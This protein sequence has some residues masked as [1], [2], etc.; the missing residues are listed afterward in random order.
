MKHKDS[1]SNRVTGGLHTSG[2]TCLY[3]THTQRHTT[4]WRSSALS[5]WRQFS[6]NNRVKAIKHYCLSIRSPRESNIKSCTINKSIFLA[7]PRLELWQSIISPLRQKS[8]IRREQHR[9]CATSKHTGRLSSLLQSSRD[10]ILCSW[11]CERRVWT[12]LMLVS[13]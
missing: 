8:V 11:G 10:I 7:L 4:I 13:T 12:A 3:S 1:F 6:G 9:G 5:K 2:N